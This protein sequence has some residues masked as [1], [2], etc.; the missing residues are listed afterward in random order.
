MFR[1]LANM[2]LWK[3]I[4]I[5]TV[6]GLAVG[7]GVF[8]A[9]GMKAV[10]EATEGMLQERLTIAH[11]VADYVNE[12]LI[13]AQN[14]MQDAVGQIQASGGLDNLPPIFADLEGEY[15]RLSIQTSGVF[16]LDEN[17]DTI[18]GMPAALNSTVMDPA[19]QPDISQALAQNKPTVSRMVSLTGS[20]NPVIFLLN[21]V[22]LG[23]DKPTLLLAVAVD[24]AQSSIGV[25]V[26][27]VTLGQTGY[28]ELVDQAGIVI[29]R[30]TPGPKLK[31][32]ELSDH[33]GR[34]V[35]LIDAGQP[36][37]GICHNCHQANNTVVS[38][39]VL[40]FVPLSA[41]HW[42]VVVRQSEAEALAPARNLLKNII[43]FGA[44]LAATA[45]LIVFIIN[46]QVGSRISTLTAASR[47]I[48]AGDLTSPVRFLGGDEVGKLATSFDEMRGKLKTSYDNLEQKTR[49]L[50]SLLSVSEV[51]A[52]AQELP[53]LLA[54]V[55]KKATEV[56]PGVEAGLLLVASSDRQSLVVQSAA[57]FEKGSLVQSEIAVDASTCGKDEDWLKIDDKKCASLLSGLFRPGTPVREI[58]SAGCA[59]IVQR[60]ACNGLLVV[61]RFGSEKEFSDS[62]RRLLQAIADDVSI[63][64]ERDRLIRDADE[65]RALHEAD[66]LRSQFISSV[67]HELRTPLTI[68]KGYATT[69]LRESVNWDKTTQQEFLHN[70][71]E[72]TDE[73]REL[74][75]KILQSAKLEAGA[76]RLEKEPLLIPRLA[77]R[78]IEENVQRSKRHRFTAKF[79]PS[80][81]VVEADTRCVEQVVRNLVENAIK[82]SPQGGEISIS[83]QR[84]DGEVVVTVS[85]HGI[86]I[87]PQFQ[88]KVFERFYRVDNRLT[89]GVSGSGLGLSICK[90]HIKAHGGRIWLESIPGKGSSFHFSLP[91]N[92]AEE[93]EKN[94]PK[95]EI[96]DA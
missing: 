83:G 52:S 31:P 22:H 64:L 16:L 26:R 53:A 1:F 41:S 54:A 23:P 81:P 67:T 96:D 55:V 30:T 93:Q 84:E 3:K 29:T 35:A 63:A 57:G 89:R 38:R 48:A 91:L 80:F 21:P 49:E 18:S 90:G 32:F 95:G 24:L 88:D 94:Q 20:D 92:P 43:L 46:R 39:D 34:F 17:G 33:S 5:L 75:D 40:A 14:E 2:S 11:L 42:G 61:L 82:Y 4:M 86:G 73:L 79:E 8:S 74:I 7:V 76:F 6:C 25:F 50:A 85:D 9:L 13:R 44:A 51:L 87:A 59:R 45:L 69:L 77:R 15:A 19:M 37:R 36:T 66:K 60:G 71:D 58:K 27:P 72:K 62:D 47:K 10:N 70:I 78:I 12:A 56:I 28:V 68:I 65:A